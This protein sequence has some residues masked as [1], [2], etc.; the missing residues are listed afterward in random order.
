MIRTLLVVLVVSLPAVAVSQ[1][2]KTKSEAKSEAKS[3][4]KSEGLEM[5]VVESATRPDFTT[6]LFVA[7]GL[8]CVLL[9]AFTFWTV[10]Q[11][12]SLAKRAE[13]L[14]ERFD[15]AYPEERDDSDKKQ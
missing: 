13:Y 11:G 12:R 4:A 14:R 10:M 1:D 8:T 15:R 3:D 5:K 9:G 6:H 7:Y 2:A